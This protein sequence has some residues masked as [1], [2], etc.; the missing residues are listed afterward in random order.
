M[1]SQF[2]SYKTNYKQNDKVLKAWC[3]SGVG[4]VNIYDKHKR[5]YLFLF[6][7]VTYIIW[8]VEEW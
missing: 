7:M 6:E 4:G 5:F 3:V 8:E 1:T 2:T